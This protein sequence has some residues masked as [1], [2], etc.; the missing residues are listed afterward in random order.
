LAI[1]LAKQV[2]AKAREKCRSLEWQVKSRY[3]EGQDHGRNA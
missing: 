3:Q 2:A 1:F